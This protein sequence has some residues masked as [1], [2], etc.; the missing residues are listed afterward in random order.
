VKGS[1]GCFADALSKDWWPDYRMGVV[2]E[3]DGKP[4]GDKCEARLMTLASLK[5]K[6]KK[7]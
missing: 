4:P 7:E 6:R 1:A 5:R 2:G 3:H